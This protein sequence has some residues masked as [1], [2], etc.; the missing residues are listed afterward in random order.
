MRV[1][2]TPVHQDT[3]SHGPRG[4]KTCFIQYQKEHGAN[5]KKHVS[6]NIT[7]STRQRKK[8]DP[9]QRDGSQTKINTDHVKHR[10]EDKRKANISII[11]YTTLA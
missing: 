6:Y 11:M 3:V 7:W 1:I 2:E 8:K 10:K 4:K 9:P 5:K